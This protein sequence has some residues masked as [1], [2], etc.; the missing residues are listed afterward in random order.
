[1]TLHLRPIPKGPRRKADTRALCEARA[2]I[3]TDLK[4]ELAEQEM[5][6]HMPRHFNARQQYRQHGGQ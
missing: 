1:M 3:H 5:D 4:S 6:R 2:R